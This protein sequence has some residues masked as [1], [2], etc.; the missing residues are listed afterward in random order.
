ML[1]L[2]N[3]RQLL[4]YV[5][6]SVVRPLLTD[7]RSPGKGDFFIFQEYLLLEMPF[8]PSDSPRRIF[9]VICCVQCRILP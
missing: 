2:S 4:L 3:I 9:Q 7:L 6:V 1:H 5:V 8:L